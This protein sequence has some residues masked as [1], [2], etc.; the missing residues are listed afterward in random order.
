MSTLT[1]ELPPDLSPERLLLAV[2]LCE[3]GEVPLGYA[4][5]M[6]RCSLG[7]FAERLGQRGIPVLDH[8]PDDLDALAST[9][10]RMSDGLRRHVLV[11]A[12]E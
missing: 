6:A 8:P 5:E 4:A 2:Q 11:R 7:G 9:G 3:D 1:I 10:V 12:D